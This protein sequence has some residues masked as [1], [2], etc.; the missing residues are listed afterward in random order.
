MQDPNHQRELGSKPK[1]PTVVTIAGIIWIVNACLIGLIILVLLLLLFGFPAVF[2]PE[3]V[4]SFFFGLFI[5]AFIGVGHQ[6]VRGTARATFVNGIASILF[7]IFIL[8]PCIA[9][10]V[11]GSGI[12]EARAGWRITLGVGLLGGAGLITAGILWLVGLSQ[13]RAWRIQAGR[14]RIKEALAALLRRDNPDAFVIFEEKRSRKFVQFA[15]SA[16]EERLL[17]D[18]PSQILDAGESQRAEEY[19]QQLGVR[20]EEY[21]V[22]DRPGGKAV[23]RRRNFLKDF[24]KDVEAATRV[25]Q[26]VFERVYQLPPDFDLVVEE[27]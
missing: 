10:F 17:L 16:N 4:V 22:F 15:G 5:W 13:Y 7:G 2:P 18:L 14:S 25:T 6:S 12:F 9:I 11:R 23:G 1:Y 24:G 27:N 26:E 20:A 21:D 3:S 8:G 19:F